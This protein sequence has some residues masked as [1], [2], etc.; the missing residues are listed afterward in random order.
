[1]RS[2]CSARCNRNAALTEVSGLRSVSIRDRVPRGIVKIQP[3]SG[4]V[5]TGVHGLA[6]HRLNR[7]RTPVA[8]VAFL[9]LYCYQAAPAFWRLLTNSVDDVRFRPY[10]AIDINARC[11]A[12][13]LPLKD[14]SAPALD[15]VA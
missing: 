2:T 8:I 9:A 10:L 15:R 6:C 11:W 12:R 13:N 7:T 3:D 14:S 5:Q 4:S 1:M